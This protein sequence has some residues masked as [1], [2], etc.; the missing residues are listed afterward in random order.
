M[1]AISEIVLDTHL[2][3]RKL[4]E[5]LHLKEQEEKE[6]LFSYLHSRS[7]RIRKPGKYLSQAL[8]TNV[9]EMKDDNIDLKDDEG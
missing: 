2:G 8:R 4:D 3:R 7:K 1:M 9:T 5:F 6:D